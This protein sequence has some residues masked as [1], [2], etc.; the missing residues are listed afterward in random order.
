MTRLRG[1]LAIALAVC[2][3]GAW[4][5]AKPAAQTADEI[6][7][8]NI[9]AKGGLQKLKAISTIKQTGTLTLQGVETP[10]TIYSKRP[11]LQRQE[12]TVGDKMV[13]NGFDGVTA[14]IINP[15]LG[16]PGPIQV[17]GPQADAIREQ[18]NF[19]GPLVDYKRQ[20][21]TIAVVPGDDMLDG[22]KLIHLKLTTRLQNVTHLYLDA[23]TYLEAKMQTVTPRMT[24][25][26]QILDFRDVDGVKV[27][28]RTRTM[29][30]GQIQSE[31]KLESVEFDT[32]MELSLFK[33]KA[34]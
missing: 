8:K 32:P 5:D 28:F 22:R 13:V 21:T 25:E 10:V 34:S 2:L 11:N 31:L 18:S 24:V 12:I 16:A 7:G 30:N 9:Q 19:D 29:A 3:A 23:E 26:Q 1:A 20:G 33:A 27:A 6:V 14:W 4:Q 17:T 15:L